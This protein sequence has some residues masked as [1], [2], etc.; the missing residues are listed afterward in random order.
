MIAKSAFAGV[1]RSENGKIEHPSDKTNFRRESAMY[2][3]HI[4][5]VYH[6]DDDV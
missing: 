1:A 4:S 2:F 3:I 5:I 6:T